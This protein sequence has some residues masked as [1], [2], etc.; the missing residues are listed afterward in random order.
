MNQSPAFS[1]VPLGSEDRTRF[2]C[3]VDAL[4]NYL[5]KQ[6]RQDFK[7]RVAA[8]F[9]A[10][11]SSTNIVAGFYTLSAADVNL[12]AI[13]DD[14]K[15]KLPRYPTVPSVLLGRL[16]VDK[17]FQGQKLGSALLSDA[18]QRSMKSDII[19]HMMLVDAKDDVAATFYQQH[20]FRHF[21][22][23]KNRLYAPLNQL[24]KSV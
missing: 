17:N 18:V 1:V 15:K 4:N 8:C 16:A 10:L 24:I 19:A 22:H 3:G 7:K 5:H 23:M 12:T 21:H 9:I 14:W 13:D 6:A 20:G 2:D 11:E